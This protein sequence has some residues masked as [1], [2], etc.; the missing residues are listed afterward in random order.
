MYLQLEPPHLLERD[1]SAAAREMALGLS[2]ERFSETGGE[3]KGEGPGPLPAGQ[4]IT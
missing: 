4:H 3:S 1:G 2:L